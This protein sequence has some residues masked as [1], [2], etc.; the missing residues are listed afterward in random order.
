MPKAV[1]ERVGLDITRPFKYL[2]YFDSIKVRCL[3][4][5]KDLC[6]TLDRTPTKSLVMDIMVA[7]IP[8]KYG[9]LFSC[10]WGVKIQGTLQMDMIYATIPMFIQQRRMYKETLM[11]YTVSSKEKSHNYPL[12]YVY[13]EL[14]SFILY[15]EEDFDTHVTKAKNGIDKKHEN[16]AIIV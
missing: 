3:G 8:Y 13:Y 11:K 14:D 16:Q 7:D 10:S 15:N 12:Y 6:V 9:M 5:I 1:M 4:I 2:Y